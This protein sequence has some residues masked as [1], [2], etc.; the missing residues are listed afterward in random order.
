M[1]LSR[2]R[3]YKAR[4]FEGIALDRMG[5]REASGI[6]FGRAMELI[7]G[8]SSLSDPDKSHRTLYCYCRL[9]NGDWPTT[10]IRPASLRVPGR[11]DRVRHSSA[12]VSTPC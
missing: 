5:Q 9:K 10:L 6:S 12:H 11:T 3:L 4:M 7:N 8:S 2:D 1:T